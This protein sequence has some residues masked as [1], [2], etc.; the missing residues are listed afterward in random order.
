MTLTR[1]DLILGAAAAPLIA[2]PMS[3]FAQGIDVAKIVVGFPAGGGIDLVARRIADKLRPGYAKTVVVDNRPGAGGQIA[4]SAVKS[5][6]ADG[7]SLLLT[8]MSILAIY[9]HTYKKLPYDPVTDLM[10]VSR[11]VEF[12]FGVAVGPSVPASVTTVPELMAWFRA[13]PAQANY[14]TAA[15]ASTMNFIGDL[16]ARA[17]KTDMRHV[18]YRGSQLAIQDMIG[19]QVPAVVAPLGELTPHLK[20][21]RSRLLV[22]TGASRSRF[23]PKTPTLGEQGFAELAFTEWHGLFAP[24]GTPVD[25]VQR[26]NAAVRAA[27]AQPDV[28][29]AMAVQSYEVAPSTPQELGALMARD[30]QLWGKL[31]ASTGFKPEN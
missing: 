4:V 19:G 21:D 23:F 13:H 25:T 8:P 30:T 31:I 27:L 20:G 16:L 5:A 24:T 22:T 10:P 17:A 18:P 29:E 7:T 12:G 11:V 9:P 3:A 6:P 26:L 28:I 1:R 2:H 15:P 14:G